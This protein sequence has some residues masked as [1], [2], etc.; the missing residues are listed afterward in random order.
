M[1]ILR[2]I[3]KE[4]GQV[5]TCLDIHY[6]LVLKSKNEK[7]FAER[8]KLWSED[9]LKDVYGVVCFDANP[10][11]EENA[12]SL[13]PLYTEFKYYIMTSNGET[14]DNISEK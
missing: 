12:D 7:E 3:T 4:S 14:F 10:V 5:N 2:T 8:T 6:V 11:K 9:D 13:M 1:F